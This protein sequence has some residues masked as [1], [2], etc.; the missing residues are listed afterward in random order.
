MYGQSDLDAAYESELAE[1][2]TFDG[3]TAV[4]VFFDRAYRGELGMAGAEPLA[5]GRVSEFASAAACVG[6]TLLISGTTY[7]IRNWQPVDDG[8]EVELPLSEA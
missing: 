7:T 5:R 1:D 4:R 2:A 3:A 6:K 8:G